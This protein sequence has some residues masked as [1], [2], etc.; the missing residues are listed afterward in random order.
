MLSACTRRF[1]IIFQRQRQSSRSRFIFRPDTWW[2]KWTHERKNHRAF[3]CCS[4]CVACVKSLDVHAPPY[5]C[6]VVYLIY[7]HQCLTIRRVTLTNEYIYGLR[8]RVM[9]FCSN[10]LYLTSTSRLN[11]YTDFF[12]LFIYF[13]LFRIYRNL[14]KCSRDK[15]GHVRML[16]FDE[17][18]EPRW[19]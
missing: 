5:A 2:Y 15:I 7:V 9:F 1:S 14:R 3:I 4:E 13:L 11:W 19:M 16:Q 18:K 6:V 8:H 12:S 10:K 17:L